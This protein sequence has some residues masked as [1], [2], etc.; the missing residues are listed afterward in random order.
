[1][2]GRL[3]QVGETALNGMPGEG[4]CGNPKPKTQRGGGGGGGDL[5]FH[6]THY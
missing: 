1:M 6:Y 5:F 3:G 4:E 2:R